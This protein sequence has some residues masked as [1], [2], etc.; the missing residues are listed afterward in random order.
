MQRGKNAAVPVFHLWVQLVFSNNA[1]TLSAP[2]GPGKSAAGYAKIKTFMH[3][4]P[5]DRL[6]RSV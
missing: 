1:S 2:R 4:A 6:Q 3:E 5:L